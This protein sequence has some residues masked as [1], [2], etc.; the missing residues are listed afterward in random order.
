MLPTG[1]FENYHLHGS[2]DRSWIKDGR[3]SV[4]RDGSGNHVMSLIIPAAEEEGE[5]GMRVFEYTFEPGTPSSFI[6]R[7]RSESRGDRDGLPTMARDP[8]QADGSPA[9]KQV[10]PGRP[11][12]TQ[13]G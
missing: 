10:T 12:R 8:G 2:P 3:Q 11:R 5:I 4:I 13:A 7:A 6:A 9:G 1:H